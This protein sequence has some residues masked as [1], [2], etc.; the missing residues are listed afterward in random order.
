[1]T[2]VHDG[3]VAFLAESGRFLD[4]ASESNA[5]MRIVPVWLLHDFIRSTE[6]G[7]HPLPVRQQGNRMY[8]F[9]WRI[10]IIWFY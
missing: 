5:N 9:I 4:P 6:A 1:M 3:S 7:T 8:G 2:E 10:P